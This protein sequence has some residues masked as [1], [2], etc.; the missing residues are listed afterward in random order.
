M[1]GEKLLA[2][3]NRLMMIARIVD[4]LCIASEAINTAEGI[5]TNIIQKMGKEQNCRDICVLAGK[6]YEYD[7][8][9]PEERAEIVK[10]SARKFGWVLYE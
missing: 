7:I 5:C 6:K 10:D 9:G 1:L 2:N 4:R 8:S 3:D